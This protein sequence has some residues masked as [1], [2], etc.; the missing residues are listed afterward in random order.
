MLI[1][2]MEETEHDS[3]DKFALANA[4]ISVICK[5]KQTYPSSATNWANDLYSTRLDHPEEHKVENTGMED[6][7]REQKTGLAFLVDSLTRRFAYICS[8]VYDYYTCKGI[9]K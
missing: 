3:R 4:T 9:S 5:P 2:D 1:R 7:G 6:L 8:A